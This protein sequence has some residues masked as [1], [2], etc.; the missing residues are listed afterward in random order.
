MKRLDPWG[1]LIQTQEEGI[2]A[3]LYS[4]EKNWKNLLEVIFEDSSLEEILAFAL[5][6][7]KIPHYTSDAECTRFN[8]RITSFQER[9][10]DFEEDWDRRRID[11]NMPSPDYYEKVVLLLELPEGLI[12]RGSRSWKIEI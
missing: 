8:R 7:D 12:Q 9:K 2:S 4:I 6:L 10:E 5:R 3:T 11:E 1:E